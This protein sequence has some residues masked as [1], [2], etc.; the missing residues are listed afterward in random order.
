VGPEAAAS[1]G[2]KAVVAEEAKVPVWRSGRWRPGQWMSQGTSVEESGGSGSSAAAGT[3]MEESGLTGGGGHIDLDDRV[4]EEGS[5][6][7]WGWARGFG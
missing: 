3:V 5:E 2:P 1:V 7:G 6:W 4:R